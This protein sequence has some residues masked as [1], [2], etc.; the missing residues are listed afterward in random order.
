MFN[1]STFLDKFKTL[2]M[3]DIAAKEAMVQA[4]QKCAGVILQKEK[5]DYKGGIMYIKTD[6]SQKNQMYIK[7]DS[8]INYLESD[9]NV[10]I[11]D[12]R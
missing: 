1:I 11:K 12:I 5:I 10:R 7:K 9:F 6:S 2:G 3:A 8:I 4:A